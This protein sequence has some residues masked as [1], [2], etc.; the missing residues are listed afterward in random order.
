VKV[1]LDL[2]KANSAM[3]KVPGKDAKPEDIAKFHKAIG[4]PETVDGYKYE[5]GGREATPAD[6]A[7]QGELSKVALAAGVPAS[8]MAALSKTVTALATA[9][10]DEQNRVA[11]EGRAS[12]E[13]AL[14]K[15]WGADYDAN[16]TLATRAVQAFGEIKSHPEVIDFFD[17][18]MVN[19]QKLGDHPVMVRMLGNIG[20]R[21][22]E[23]DFI[24]AVG[25][26]ERTSL[27]T[28]VNNLMSANPPGTEGY[29]KVAGRIMEINEQLHGTGGI[30]GQSG[31]SV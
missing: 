17:K 15:E 30:V 25:G 22:G 18:T 16:K 10:M 7:I 4:V 6:K 2:R 27:Q 19:G 29:K 12:A 26:S 24:G 31:R 8:A 28:E 21:M 5:M 3:I 23:G 13:A 11:I 14:R 9:Q 20:R 1:A